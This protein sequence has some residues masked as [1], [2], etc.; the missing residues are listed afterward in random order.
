M[1]FASQGN[2][3]VE[4][5]IEHVKQCIDNAYKNLS[6]L[7]QNPAILEELQGMSGWKTR[8]LYNNICNLPE[9]FTHLEIGSYMGSSIISALFDNLNAVGIAVDNFSEFQGPREELCKNLASYLKGQDNYIVID[10]DCWNIKELPENRL[11]TTYL[12][13]G[14]HNLEAQTKAITHF[15]K[16]CTKYFIL[17]VDDSA[18]DS[19]T[20]AMKGTRE[21]I[22]QAGLKIHFEYDIPMTTSAYHQGGDSFWNGCYVAVLERTDI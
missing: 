7:N 12:Y 18:T 13:D 22:K 1:D 9:R 6:K 20:N 4:F 2:F 19:W 15:Y 8:H 3:T 5:L 10:D 16:M 11:A 21:G 14:V 17:M